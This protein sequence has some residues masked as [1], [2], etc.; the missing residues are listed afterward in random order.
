MMR[1]TT[2]IP[3]SLECVLVL[4]FLAVMMGSP[5][6]AEAGTVIRLG[7][8]QPAGTP[9]DNFAR[10]LGRAVNERSKG[11]LTVQVFPSSQLG[12]ERDM[13]ES[14]QLGAVEL[15]VQGD[16]LMSIVAPEWGL[17]LTTPFVI[18]SKEHFRRV[19]DGPLMKPAYD[20]LLERKGIRHLGWVDRG[21][22]YLTTN[23]PIREPA[24]VKGLKIRVPDGVEA[25]VVAWKLLGA[26][27]V[28][29]D[30][31]EVF[32]GLRQGTVDAEE[33]PLEMINSN[34]FYEV[35]K[36][37]NLT[38]HLYTG[39]EIVASEKWFKTLSPGLQK[40][41]TDAA[42]DAVAFGNKAQ[43]ADEARFEALL[44]Q[45][46]M[47]FNPVDRPKFEEAL[48]DLPK[49]PFAAKWKPGFFEAVKAVQ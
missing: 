43:A 36:Y 47:T 39:F 31:S 9:V 16:I 28:P 25:Y 8:G 13:V 49:Q 10:E 22:R 27:V 48:K 38:A 19:V 24:E 20:A 41:I 2:P 29:M 21:P 7:H 4:S 15:N 26:A 46:G 35:Q 5:G 12:K 14:L 17:V 3:K 33:N 34:S 37:V 30:I 6:S 44:K 40:V 11:E 23:K 32:L 42:A 1:R 45:K 18:R